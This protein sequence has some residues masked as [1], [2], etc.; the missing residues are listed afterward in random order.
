MK[1]ILIL[2]GGGSSEHEISKISCDYLVSQI[3]TS[4]FNILKV[5]ITKGFIWK[6]DE[7]IVE[8]NF[9]KV[10]VSDGKA[11]SKI[12]YVIPCIHGYPGETGD[13]QSYLD[14][15]SVP[16][17]GVGAEASKIC[18]NKVLTKLWLQKLN[19]PTADFLFFNKS[20][21]DDEQ[22]Q[23]RSLEFLEKKSKVFIKASNQGSSIGC[24]SA[25]TKEELRDSIKDAFNF[26]DFV[27]VES[28]IKGRELE[29]AVFEF[30]NKIHATKPGEIHCPS[31]FYDFDQKYKDN[32]QTQIDILAKN[33]S[34]E[35]TKQITTMAKDVFKALS[36]K[37]LSR[38][39][40]FL[41]DHGEILINEIN[42]FPGM[43]PISLFPQMMENSGVPFS[44]FLTQRIISDIL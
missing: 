34:P 8:L 24:Y 27:L 31:D 22:I 32:S 35:I 38:I 28:F 33:L 2:F 11:L 30:D 19:F 25:L 37:G 6:L 13:I 1:N 10:L 12:D 23:E 40:F 42:T 36:L 7:K 16:Y 14:L 17:L 26:S 3:D 29:V 9:D 43:T 5:E 39:D 44:D 4:K 21:K 15:V 18:F 20:N 41:T